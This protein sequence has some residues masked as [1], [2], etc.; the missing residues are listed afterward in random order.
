MTDTMTS[1]DD[2]D[3]AFTIAPEQRAALAEKFRANT[4]LDPEKGCLVWMRGAT[5]VG[6]GTIS[7]GGKTRAAHRVAYAL[8]NG[9]IPKGL[10]VRHTC[11]NPLCVN[12]VHLSIG[13]HQDNM[14]D[15]VAAGRAAI[16]SGRKLSDEKIAMIVGMRIRGA[17]QQAIA[18]EFDVSLKTVQLILNNHTW[19]DALENELDRDLERRRDA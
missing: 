12:P 7:V 8:A 5:G 13:T 11:N 1:V 3:E 6:Y 15:M 19:I 2:D 16:G 14:N 10:V 4:T 17:T 9:S 18:D